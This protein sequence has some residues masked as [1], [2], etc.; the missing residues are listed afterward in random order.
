MPEEAGYV[1]GHSEEE[2]QCLQL[3]AGCLEDLTHR[4]SH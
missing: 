4:L 2:L 1:L 3:Q